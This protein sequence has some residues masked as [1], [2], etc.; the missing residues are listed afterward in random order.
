MMPKAPISNG[1]PIPHSIAEHRKVVDKLFRVRQDEQIAAATARAEYSF[2]TSLK[3]DT[4]DTAYMRQ[5]VFEMHQ[6]EIDRTLV[7]LR[8]AIVYSRMI[9]ASKLDDDRRVQ[10]PFDRYLDWDESDED[11][12]SDKDEDDATPEADYAN[13]FLNLEGDNSDAMELEIGGL[14]LGG[15]D[16]AGG[17][18]L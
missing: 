1:P 12:T 14:T 17:S 10:F 4:D 16:T 7:D 15:D 6:L 2:A 8:R 13:D 9:D 18:C 3:L 5:L 11:D